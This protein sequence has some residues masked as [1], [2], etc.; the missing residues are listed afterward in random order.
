[1]ET[2][3]RKTHIQIVRERDV[4]SYIIM[5]IETVYPSTSY[6][7]TYSYPYWDEGGSAFLS[8]K[9]R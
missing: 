6:H 8:S 5:W 1:M 7:R 3:A 9:H 2:K 4:W